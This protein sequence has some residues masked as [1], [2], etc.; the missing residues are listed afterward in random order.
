M[1]FLA[2]I[3]SRPNADIYGLKVLKED[4]QN[5]TNNSTRFIIVTG[6]KIYKKDAGKISICFEVPHESG[7]LYKMLA[8]I[9]YNNLNMNK[10]ESRPIQGKMWEYRFFIDFEGNLNDSAVQNALR[11]IEEE[12]TKLRVLGNY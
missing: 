5:N 6:K 7:S 4:F 2:A 11:G 1:I 12:A 3:A 8:H 9:I 10:I